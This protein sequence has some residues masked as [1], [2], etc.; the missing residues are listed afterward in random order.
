M[1]I[2]LP[3]VGLAM[4]AG[5]LISLGFWT[6]TVVH[7]FLLPDPRWSMLTYALRHT[8]DSPSLRMVALEALFKG[9]GPIFAVLYIL[10]ELDSPEY[11]HVVRGTRIV[12]G[13][14][15]ARRTRSKRNKRA[16]G[17]GAISEQVEV[18]GIRMPVACE[19]NHLLLAGSTN[20]GKSVAIDKLLASALGRGDRC[21]VIDPNG[22]SLS[23]FGKEGDVVLNPFDKRSPGWSIFNE[24]RKPYDFERYAKSV[25]PDSGDPSSQQWHAYAQ[26]LFAATVRMMAEAGETTTERLLYW[27]TQARAKELAD[28]LAGSTAVGLFEPGAEKALASTRF[29]LTHHLSAFQFVQPGDFSLR[30]WLETGKGNLYITWRED[31][32]SSLKPLV[33]A[34]VDILTASILTLP[35]DQPRPLWLIL[36][37]LASLERLS[38]LEAGLTKGR[39]HGLRV[40]AGLQSISQLDALYGQHNAKILRSCFR[41]ILALGCANADPDTAEAISHGLGQSE[42]EVTQ[43]THS[44]SQSGNS[45]STS[46]HRSVEY[47]VLPSELM[48]LPPLHGFLK[49]AGDFPIGRVRLIH[50]DYPV[51]MQ[52]FVER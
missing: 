45:S 5:L 28:F 35:T 26:Q 42:I 3:I 4:L 19:S 29:I 16:P 43:S 14:E 22:H 11:G 18:A 25:I 44:N 32:L 36:D 2:T 38:S 51:R 1:K 30:E 31:M 49:L 50:R 40:V 24:F 21:I 33:S 41:N 37:E 48:S 12:S 6:W 52:P 20:T 8:F 47:A 10:N 13:H 34:W 23:K 9:F 15:L 39:K 17:V 46:R 27:L 7:Q